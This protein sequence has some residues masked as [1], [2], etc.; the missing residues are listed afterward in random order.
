MSETNNEPT[1]KGMKDVFESVE[2]IKC[3][4]R[5]SLEFVEEFLSE[6]M[7]GRCL[8][9]SLGS[10]EAMIRLRK[11]SDGAGGQEDIDAL[12]R[13]SRRMLEGSMCKKGKDTAKFILESLK[14]EV[15]KEHIDRRCRE[16]ECRSLVT[17][18]VIPEKC[19]MCGFCRDACGY[20]AILGEKR[21]PYLS[22]Y[23]PFEIRQKRCVKCGEC[24]AACSYGAI[25]ITEEKIEALV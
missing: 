23:M 17:Y 10:Y 25:E 4:I 16:L 12:D 24:K 8:P 3:D 5:R 20:N 22:C 2:N 15:C 6:P 1:K 18:R 7:C 13:I 19:V 14:S 21:T 11:I 9:C